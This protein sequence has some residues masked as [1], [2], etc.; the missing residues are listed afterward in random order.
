MKSHPGRSGGGIQIFSQERHVGSAVAQ[1]DKMAFSPVLW[2]NPGREEDVMQHMLMLEPGGRWVNVRYVGPVSLEDLKAIHDHMTQKSWW[3]PDL[4]RLF[5]YQ[6]AMLGEIGFLEAS[7]HLLPYMRSRRARLFG[8]GPVPQAHVCANPLKAAMLHYW[9]RLSD[10]NLPVRNRLFDRRLE[11]EDWL[12]DKFEPV[13]D[14][15]LEPA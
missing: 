12:V 8:S 14:T 11:A 4:P 1:S 3:R 15:A 13:A 2:H 10:Q 6:Q 5:D 9:T 7:D